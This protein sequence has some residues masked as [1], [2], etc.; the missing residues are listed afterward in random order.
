MQA[1]S[2]ASS[3]ASTATTAKPGAVGHT[4]GVEDEFAAFELE[5]SGVKPGK[6]L[7]QKYS[8]TQKII[9]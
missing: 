2:E 6:F 7:I 1:K 5:A 9:Q 3:S 4:V 8:Y